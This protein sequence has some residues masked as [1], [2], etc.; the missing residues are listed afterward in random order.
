MSS[1]VTEEQRRYG[2]DGSVVGG[3]QADG[4]G[5]ALRGSTELGF[6]NRAVSWAH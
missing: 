2:W 6:G 3:F 5:R 1:T 4:T